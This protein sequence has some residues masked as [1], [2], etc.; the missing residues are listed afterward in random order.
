M[1]RCRNLDQRIKLDQEIKDEKINKHLHKT[2]NEYCSYR[3]QTIE[4]KGRQYD[5]YEFHCKYYEEVYSYIDFL[6]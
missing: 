3:K 2:F 6:K 4:F 5:L 1:K